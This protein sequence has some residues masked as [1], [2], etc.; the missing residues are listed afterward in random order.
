MPSA[1]QKSFLKMYHVTKNLNRKLIR[2]TSS[3]EPREQ[4]YVDLSDY[5]RYLNQSW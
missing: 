5:K 1:R 2:V 3:N 4:E